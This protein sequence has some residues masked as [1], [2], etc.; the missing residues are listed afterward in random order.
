MHTH[1][2]KGSVPMKYDSEQFAGSG[3]SSIISASVEV[4]CGAGSSFGVSKPSPAVPLIFLLSHVLFEEV[5][6]LP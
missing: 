2:S 1:V 6:A 3:V 5:L 4:T